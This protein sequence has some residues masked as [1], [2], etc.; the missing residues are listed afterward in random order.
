MI[1]ST[2]R[3]TFVTALLDLGRGDDDAGLASSQQRNFNEYLAHFE[4]L[5]SI[6]APLL[7]YTSVNLEPFVWRHRHPHNTRVHRLSQASLEEDFDGFAAVQDIRGRKDWLAQA[8]WLAG[9]PQARLAHYNPLVM[10]K[11]KLLCDGAGENP[12]SSDYFLWIDAGITR[13]CAGLVTH[14]GWLSVIEGL[15]QKFLICSYPYL[16]GKEIHGFPR[17]DMA[18]WTRTDGVRWVARGGLFGGSRELIAMVKGVYDEVLKSTLAEGLMGTEESVLT[19]V[20][21]RHPEFFQRESLSEDGLLRPFFERLIAKGS[22]GNDNPRELLRSPGAPAPLPLPRRNTADTSLSVYVLTFNCPEQLR[23]FFQSWHRA[24]GE[25]ESLSLYVVDNSTDPACIR[26]NQRLCNRYGGVHI[27]HGNLGISGGRQFV[28]E[29]F[30]ASGAQF[31]LFL[32]D[33]M[34]CSHTEG[35]C[36]KGMSTLVDQ[37]LPRALAVLRKEKLDFLKLS[38]SEFF[39]S[40][41][42]QWAWHNV[43]EERRR[44]LWP[45]HPRRSAGLALEDMPPTHFDRQESL[46]GLPY[47]VGEVFYCNWPQLV[48]RMGNQRLFLETRFEQPNESTWMAHVYECSRRGQIHGGVLLVSPINH[49]REYF[50]KAEERLES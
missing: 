25:L 33:D 40:N 29:H 42:Q 6:D 27:A 41:D 22:T 26:S 11:L 28:A 39:G 23:L 9:S 1:E 45:D 24:L 30:H 44:Q 35:V 21:H 19:I 13:T 4:Q 46:D 34:L 3:V 5:L 7:I 18:R 47:A 16:G 32:E 12:F 14:G 17:A 38:F 43:S 37:L 10:S 49:R 15:L 31:M 48:S 8:G 50:Y 36:P 2:P 20:A